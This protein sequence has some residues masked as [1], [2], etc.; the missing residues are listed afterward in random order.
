MEHQTKAKQIVGKMTSV[1]AILSVMIIWTLCY[2]VMSYADLLKGAV[3]DKEQFA[4]VKEVFVYVM[5]IMSGIAGSVVTLYF[6]RTDRH[7]SDKDKE[8]KIEPIK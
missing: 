7:D 1:R 4:L 8:D 5:G 6:T 2:V 3:A